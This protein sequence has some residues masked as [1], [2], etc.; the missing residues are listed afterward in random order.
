MPSIRDFL[1]E[2]AVPDVS[3]SPSGRYLAFVQA[4]QTRGEITPD[5]LIVL[6]LET[7][8]ARPTARSLGSARVI[9]LQWASEDR[10]LIRA[11]AD[12]EDRIAGERIIAMGREGGDA[13]VLFEETGRVGASNFSASLISAMLLDDPEHV[14]MPAWLGRRLSLW[15]VNI[16]T[17]E[18]E[19]LEQGGNWTLAW[20][21]NAEGDAVVRVDTSIG[22]STLEYFVRRA[23][24][25]GWTKVHEVERQVL[26][27]QND[28]WAWVG[29][30]PE[31]DKIFVLATPEGED[32]TGVYEFDLRTGTYGDLVYQHDD[33]DVWSVSRDPGSLLPVAFHTIVDRY[34]T[35][36]VDTDLHEHFGAVAD[37]FGG[38]VNV[39]FQGM[40]GPLMVLEVSGPQEP[41]AFYL[42]NFEQTQIIPL[43]NLFP[44]FQDVE[45]A[46]V[47]VVHYTSRDGLELRGYLT[48]PPNPAG[49]QMPLIVMP[50]GG[51]EARDWY[52]FDPWTQL[53]ASRGYAVFQPNFRGSEGFG[54]AFIEA[55]YRQWSNGM[56]NDVD[57]GV[58]A[59]ID[60]GRV[61]A[62]RMCVVGASYGGYSA[63]VSAMRTPDRYSC[64][65]SIAGI[66]DLPEFI[67]YW[68]DAHNNTYEY[69]QRAVGHPSRQEEIL[70]AASP[71]HNA[72]VITA[73]ILL[74]HGEDDY[75]V[76]VEQSEI[77]ERAMRRAGR[78]V[79]Y[80]EFEE[81]DHY[82]QETDD[83]AYMLSLVEQFLATHL[84]G[85]AGEA[86]EA[87]D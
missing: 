47:E 73:P 22:L 83:E 37:Y 74:I 69:L 29:D 28:T 66:S 39:F 24:G 26:M 53:L 31:Q 30:S 19:W 56:V 33:V 6:D 48:L 42:Y 44:Q 50:H 77:M 60:Q 76:P 25:S 17:G 87:P 54:K 20:Y 1:A 82:F 85:R 65:V 2:P 8:G 27:E 49:E 11:T 21:T 10:I 16:Y 14:I 81:V 34:E 46:P 75:N 80:V 7:E 23:D 45:L 36:F 68:R 67:R 43:A 71:A 86:E 79:Q 18:T 9:S 78:D 58:Q 52:R 70:E 32:R 3:L 4:G 15:K 38:E 84:G 72:S 13:V 51:P 35:E 64:V 63:L 61:D 55:G 5:R 59:L 12:V 57:D 41:G 62:D 40:A